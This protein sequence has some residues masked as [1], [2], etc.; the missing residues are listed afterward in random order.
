[1]YIIAQKLQG[2]RGK[3]QPGEEDPFLLGCG[4]T[5]VSFALSQ[6]VACV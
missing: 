1:M 3:E 6:A 4:C 2:A 5:D